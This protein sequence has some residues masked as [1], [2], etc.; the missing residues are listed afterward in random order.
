VLKRLYH[1][2]F[3]KFWLFNSSSSIL[4]MASVH[5]GMGTSSI[6]RWMV[7]WLLNNKWERCDRKC[8][9]FD[10]MFYPAVCPEGL[11]KIMSSL[12]TDSL[13]F[14]TQNS[15]L[16]RRWSRSASHSYHNIGL[17]FFLHHKLFTLYSLFVV[18]N[19]PYST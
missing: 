6:Q 2:F 18:H 1:G 15:L 12:R 14:W 8:S 5:D 3:W 9:W 11:Q 19:H 10:V 17:H 7:G 13:Q 16:W 4:F